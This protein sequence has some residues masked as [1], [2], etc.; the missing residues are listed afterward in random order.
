MFFKD[1]TQIEHKEEQDRLKDR[2]AALGQMAAGLA[3]E[4]RNPLAAIE[5]TSSLLKR[6]VDDTESRTLLEKIVAEVKRLNSSVSKSLEF[7]RPV[8][9]TLEP[10]HL[11]PLIDEAIAVAKGRCLSPGIVVRREL[12][13]ELKPFLMDRSQLRQVFEN[14]VLNAMEALGDEGAI[15]ITADVIDAPAD[16]TVPYLPPGIG[17]AD[18]WPRTD[19]FVVVRVADSGPGIEEDD[20]DRIFQPLFTTKQQGSGIGLAVARKIVT[21]HRGV[22]DVASRPGQGAEF[23]IRLPMALQNPEVRNR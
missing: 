14:L 8:A 7:V 10:A 1:L 17:S 6:R 19:Q 5:V 13:L 16:A 18:P 15:T 3:H 2:L 23:S 12:P 11:E 20:L 9:L 22:I 21:S 4:I